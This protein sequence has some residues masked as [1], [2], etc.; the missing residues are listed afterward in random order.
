MEQLSGFPGVTDG[1]A[2]KFP[3]GVENDSAEKKGGLNPGLGFE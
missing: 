3:Q 2:A 1:F